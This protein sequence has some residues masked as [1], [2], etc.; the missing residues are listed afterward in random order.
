MIMAV[1]KY[2]AISKSGAKIKGNIDA[3]NIRAA[4]YLLYKNNMHVLSIKKRILL[5]NKYMIKRNSNKTD[6][7][8]I[9]RQIATLVSSS[10]PLDEVLDI[11]GKQNSKSKMI[12]IIQEIR[13]NIQ[14]GHSF[15]DALSHFPAV[16]SPLYKTMITAGEVS[17]HLGLVL[18]RLADHIEQ[19]KKIQIKIIQALIYPC[20]LI[21]ISLGVIVILL[22]AVVPNIVEQFS[23]SEKALPLSTKLLM[24]LSYGV[25]EN[26]V[27]IIA[28]TVLV[29]IFLH[30]LLKIN[31]INIFFHR[32]YLRLPIL[33]DMFVRINTSRYLRTLTTLHSNGVAIVQAMNMSNAALTNLYIKNKL[34]ISVK[35]VSEGCSLSSSLADS[36]IFTPIILHMIIS[37]ERSGKL[38]RMLETVAGVQEEDLMNQINI[39]MLLLEPIIIIVMAVFISFVIL[40][41]LQPI[42]QINSLVM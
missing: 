10:M 18:V 23:F 15:A 36:G 31:K 21:I 8:L 4:R 13:L 12:K 6:L 28:I 37:G 17:G 11:V 1:F 35:L 27:I 24:M 29:V 33:G 38:D 16:F 19:A 40:S 30:R 7:V 22:T 9:T 42:L 20:V 25:K 39:V 3:E 26:I 41:I 5:F 2:V 32:Y 14:E 34:N